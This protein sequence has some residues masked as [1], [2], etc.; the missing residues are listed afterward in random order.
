[1]TQPIRPR[2]LATV[3]AKLAEAIAAGEVTPA[4]GELEA[5]AVVCDRAQLPAEAARIR[6]WLH[7][8]EPTR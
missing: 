5:L 6:R 2:Y 8:P 1:M 7:A 4:P 3:V